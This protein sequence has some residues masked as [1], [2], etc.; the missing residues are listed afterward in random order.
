[1]LSERKSI[2]ATWRQGIFAALCVL[3]TSSCGSNQGM[4][5]GGPPFQP[6]SLSW[7][8]SFAQGVQ[9]GT[10][11]FPSVGKTA[12]LMI[13]PSATYQVT[14]GPCVTLSAS[15]VTTSVTVT[16]IATGSCMIGVAQGG[17]TLE[18]SVEVM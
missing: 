11:V 4:A 17:T 2:L 14:S 6:P 13:V 12:V 3:F 7:T 16:S 10:I 15:S 5:I 9:Q 1:M 8:A 18:L